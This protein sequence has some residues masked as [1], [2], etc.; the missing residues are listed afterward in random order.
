MIGVYLSIFVFLHNREYAENNGVFVARSTSLISVTP[1]AAN[2][3]GKLNPA[4]QAQLPYGGASLMPPPSA[5]PG[6]NRIINALVVIV[7]GTNKGL[8]GVIKDVVG[9]EKA[10]VELATNNKTVTVDLSMLKR[11]EWVEDFLIGVHSANTGSQPQDWPNIPAGHVRCRRLWVV[12]WRWCG[13]Q[14]LRWRHERGL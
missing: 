4:V 11:K 6:N 5:M 12:Q 7:K 8:V 14:S 3:L 13:C 1:K 9:G 2:D 10:R